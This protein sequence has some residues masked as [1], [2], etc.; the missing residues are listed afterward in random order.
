MRTLAAGSADTARAWSRR[1]PAFSARRR[2][3]AGAGDRRQ[4]GD[5]QLR[6][7][8][9][10]AAAAD[11]GP[12]P[13]SA[14]SSPSIRIAAA[15][16]ARSRSPSSS[17]T[18]QSLT[19]FESLA[20]STRA[21]V[22]LTGRGDARR[23]QAHARD[24][25]PDRRVGAADAARAAR[26]AGRRHSRARP[27][28]SCISHHYWDREL[29]RD[30]SI[31][32]QTL[33]LDGKPATVIGVLAPDIEIGNMSEIDVWVPLLAVAD[34]PREERTLR[35]N[36][37]LKPG[38][39]LAQAN[40]DVRARRA[41]PGPRAPARPT[42]DGPRASAPTREAMTGTTPGR[43]WC[44]SGSSS[45]SCCCW[46]A[47]TSRTS[48]SRARPDAGASWRSAPRSARAGRA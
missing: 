5:L 2:D 29:N 3:D 13:H 14:G 20:A 36:G 39:T 12:R 43:S 38:V 17:T 30:P 34:V 22:V 40:A 15:T 47:P 35:V 16:A 26:S 8:P 33:M 23:L 48:C 42:R 6:Q 10:A 46:R 44:C 1:Q 25:E 24:R 18:G 9:A 37:R 19:T 7:H 4:H 28:K 21:S 45:G 41:D 11:E 27:A 31:V 32:G